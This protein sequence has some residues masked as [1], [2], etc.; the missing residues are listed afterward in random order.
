MIGAGAFRHGG[1]WRFGALS[2]LRPVL[3]AFGFD[4]DRLSGVARPRAKRQFLAK[5]QITACYLPYSRNRAGPVPNP[6]NPARPLVRRDRSP[7]ARDAARRAEAQRARRVVDLMSGGPS[8]AESVAREG[9]S[10]RGMRKSVRALFARRGIEA[11]DGFIAVQIDRLKEAPRRSYGAMS[12]TNPTTIVRAVKIA[13]E[14]D[15]RYGFDGAA[16]GTEPRRKSLET[17]DSGAGMAPIGSSLAGEDR[18]EAEDGTERRRN[19]LKSLVS[20]AGMA[21]V[22]SSLDEED[23]ASRR[24]RPPCPRIGVPCRPLPAGRGGRK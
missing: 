1:L 20:G 22:G 2:R 6:V 5:P 3:G 23:G 24:R 21:P 7:A 12:E 19:L 17:L 18:G 11:A 15:R 10:E 4:A 16:R 13:P 8:M 14:F 9:V